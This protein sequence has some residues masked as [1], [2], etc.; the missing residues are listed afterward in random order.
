MLPN[1]MDSRARLLVR[2][3][4]PI[5]V[6][7]DDGICRLKVEAETAGP[8]GKKEREIITILRIEIGHE[9]RPQI[10]SSAAVQA[11]EFELQVCQQF[12]KQV[13]EFGHLGED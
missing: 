10:R 1:A 2:K 11:K 12:L 5:V 13:Q 3:W 7:N 4:I 8:R 9:L 6:V